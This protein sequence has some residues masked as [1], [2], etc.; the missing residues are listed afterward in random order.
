MRYRFFCET[1]N[2]SHVEEG[3]FTMEV[4]PSGS[5]HTVTSGS[6]SVLCDNDSWEDCEHDYIWHRHSL[7]H[8]VTN[9]WQIMSTDELMQASEHFCTDTDTRNL[10]FSLDEQIENGK[11]FHA[12]SCKCRA[13]REDAAI[14]ELFNRLT[15]EET[16]ELVSDLGDY[17]WKYNNLGVEGT[18]EGDVEGL[19]DYFTSTSGTSFENNGLIERGYEPIGLS[20]EELAD[21]VL[22]ILSSGTP[23]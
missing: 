3:L 2:T 8:Y 19:F 22:Y 23:V 12:R 21:R 1:C 6:V 13:G 5:D 14:S 18:T 15:Y 20:L 11:V 9:N 7:I 4:C 16:G 10:F 17:L